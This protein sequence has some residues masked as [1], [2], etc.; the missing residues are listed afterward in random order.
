MEEGHQNVVVNCLKQLRYFNED[1]LIFTNNLQLSISKQNSEY[2]QK[3][4]QLEISVFSTKDLVV[5]L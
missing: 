5:V 4:P 3:R 2:C 1:Y